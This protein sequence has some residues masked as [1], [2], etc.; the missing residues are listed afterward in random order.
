M[1]KRTKIRPKVRGS[2]YFDREILVNFADDFDG[3]AD[4][5][6]GVLGWSR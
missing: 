1:L 5:E 4:G 2:L 3:V 6:V